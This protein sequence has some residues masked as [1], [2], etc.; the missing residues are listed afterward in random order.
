MCIDSTAL[1]MRVASWIIL[2]HRYL[3]SRVALTFLLLAGINGC[4]GLDLDEVPPADVDLSGSWQLNSALSDSPSLAA[5][6]RDRGQGQSGDRSQRTQR[7]QRPQRGQG[8]QR[9]QGR[10]PGQRQSAGGRQRSRPP[11]AGG[12][13][14]VALLERD[15]LVI[16]QDYESL[17]M[18][19]DGVPY[20]DVSWGQ[21]IRGEE[22]INA[23]WQGDELLITTKGGKVPVVERYRLSA[24]GDR[25]TV[26]VE[27]GGGRDDLLFTRVFEKVLENK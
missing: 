9:G 18:S 6:T 13:Y 14:G 10:Q 26:I 23:G 19:I 2:G 22:T 4:A 27:F 25:L 3:C 8:Q 21:R 16:Q 24:G 5:I 1:P 20:R 15:T 12:G 17:G 11:G 7:G